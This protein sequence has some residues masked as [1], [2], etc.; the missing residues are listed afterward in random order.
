MTD[1]PNFSTLDN[2]ETI[3]ELV[4]DLDEL[5]GMNGNF[6]GTSKEQR[7]TI[8]SPETARDICRDLLVEIFGMRVRGL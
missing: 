4:D 8:D 7:Q 5:M 3:R 1:S 2:V 6:Y